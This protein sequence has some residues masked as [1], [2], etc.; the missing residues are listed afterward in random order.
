[1][2]GGR[3]VCALIVHACALAA[4]YMRNEDKSQQTSNARCQLL[5]PGRACQALQLWENAGS[6]HEAHR[7]AS[8]G[9]SL[10]A[11]RYDLSR[12]SET[13]KSVSLKS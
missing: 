6:V 9:V 1:M 8:H 11:S 4:S 7:R 2:E 12:S 3:H 10:Y 13:L 5:H